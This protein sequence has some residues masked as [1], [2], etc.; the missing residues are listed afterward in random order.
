MRTFE[1]ILLI[2]LAGGIGPAQA[3]DANLTPDE[4]LR[5]GYAAYKAGDAETAIEALGFAANNGNLSAMWKLGRMY[6]IG[7]MV[8]EDDRMALEIFSRVASQYAESSPYSAEAPYVSDALTNLGAYY[9]S[10]IPGTMNADPAMARRYFEYAAS[11]F[12]DADAQYALGMMFLSGQG[13]EPEP[14]Q[15][16][17]WLKRAARK[18]HVQA[19]SEFG[20]MLYEGVGIGRRAVEGLMWLSIARLANPGDPLTQARHEQAFSTASEDERRRAAEDATAWIA[21]NT[22]PAQASAPQEPPAE[23]T[24]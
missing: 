13:G 1:A 9:Q 16:A 5:S 10:G 19:Q 23:P 18:G 11:Y 15:A 3:L 6:S 17:R 4:A 20:Y 24:Q 2:V 12:G 7:D 8:P 22:P 14:R 21:R